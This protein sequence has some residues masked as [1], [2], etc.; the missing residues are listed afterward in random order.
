MADIEIGYKGST[1]ASINSGGVTTLN[2]IG[3]FCEDNITVTFNK[4]QGEAFT[5]ATTITTNPSITLSATTGTITAFY[6]GASNITPTVT[7]GYVSAGT[8]GTVKTSGMS[9][10]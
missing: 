7:P 1:I 3:T 10:Y 9:T 2:T 4:T 8:A 6:S 5:P